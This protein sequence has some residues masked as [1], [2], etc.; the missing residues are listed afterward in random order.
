MEIKAQAKHIK[1]SPKKVRQVVDLIRGLEV[2]KALTQLKFVNKR[3]TL[4]VLKL[5]N[6]AIANAVNNYEL[7]RNNLFVKEIRVDE[8][9]T[10]KRWMPRAH[11]RATTIRKR[12][13]HIGLIL[14]EIKDS[15]TVKAK[16]QKIEKPINLEEAAKK[17][18]D[19]KKGDN[20]NNKKE[21]DAKQ[22]LEVQEK[23]KPAS[24]KG[25]TGKFFQRKSG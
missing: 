3:S 8:G 23:A 19:N 1:I 9:I 10:M 4:P 25:F 14:G 22:E 7:D 16:K 6:S 20:I 24:K 12:T 17:M 13:S 18:E 5:L 15:G 11:G 2:E 21:K